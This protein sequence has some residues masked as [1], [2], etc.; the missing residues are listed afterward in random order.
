MSFYK[1]AL[2]L[3]FYLIILC[4]TSIAEDN[5]NCFKVLKDQTVLAK[6]QKSYE[7]IKTITANFKQNS[8]L[9]GL[10]QTQ[11]SIGRLKFKKPG[12]MNWEYQTP[13]KQI[14]NSDNQYFYWIQP[15]LEQVTIS[16]FS[17]T[18]NSSLP[19]SFLLGIGNI[20]DS[21]TSEELCENSAKNL[22]VKLKSKNKEQDFEKLS[23]LIDPNNHSPLGVK[24]IDIAGNKTE[25]IF[26]DTK[27]NLDIS[28]DSFKSLIP[29]EYDII[30]RRKNDLSIPDDSNN[31]KEEDI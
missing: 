5:F 30:D 26:E 16:D 25:I 28:S 13:E 19:V 27:Y 18:F 6:I 1:F 7:K 29:N 10:D 12:L 17:K 14:F 4:N 2:T 3:P 23:L 24:I 15:N 21:F 20:E 9:L 22:I 11:T 8:Y 31:L